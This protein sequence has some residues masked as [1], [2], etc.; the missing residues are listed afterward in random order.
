MG[1]PL[2]GQPVLE[3]VYHVTLADVRARQV[4]GQS[5]AD[6]QNTCF[7]LAEIAIDVRLWSRSWPIGWTP[8]SWPSYGVRRHRAPWSMPA[9]NCLVVM[10]VMKDVI[11]RAL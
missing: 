8:P 2:T 10:E 1:G 9:C 7:K 3:G 4:F 5:V 11:S 6:F